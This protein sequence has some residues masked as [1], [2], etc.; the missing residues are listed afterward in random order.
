ML[1]DMSLFQVV[2]FLGIYICCYAR[3]G[4][5]AVGTF[6]PKKLNF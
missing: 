2:C 6:I 4:R 5:F 1:V 3:M